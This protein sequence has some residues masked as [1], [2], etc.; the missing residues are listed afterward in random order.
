VA[1]QFHDPPAIEPFAASVVGADRRIVLGKK[2]GIDNIRL[3]CA[4]L[5]ID[6]PEATQRALLADVKAVAAT[7]R[8]L[9]TDEE[10][11]AL[12]DRLAVQQD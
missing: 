12:V 11:Q 4:E 2:S 5:G 7:K 3:K 8:D 6:L 10:F 9:V 1:S